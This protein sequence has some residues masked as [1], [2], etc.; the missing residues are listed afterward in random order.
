[1]LGGGGAVVGESRAVLEEEELLSV[2]GFSV[3]EAEGSEEA[4]GGEMVWRRAVK[5]W[6]GCRREAARVRKP[7]NMLC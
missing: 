7:V 4:E 1:M 6:E 5:G 3:V 2:W